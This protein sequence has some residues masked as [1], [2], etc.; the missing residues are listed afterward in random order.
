LIHSVP[1]SPTR[2]FRLAFLAPKKRCIR[3]EFHGTQCRLRGYPPLG[4]DEAGGTLGTPV[5]LA[6]N[7]IVTMEEGAMWFALFSIACAAAVCLSVAAV[8]LQ[9]SQGDALRG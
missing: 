9:A 5:E 1:P 7:R 3:D 6:D 2:R 4:I 8:V